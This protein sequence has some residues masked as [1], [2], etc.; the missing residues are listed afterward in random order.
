MVGGPAGYTV[1]FHAG[2]GAAHAGYLESAV[3][4]QE[5]Q[6]NGTLAPASAS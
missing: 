4:V 6:A 1:S 3:T 5:Y 2:T